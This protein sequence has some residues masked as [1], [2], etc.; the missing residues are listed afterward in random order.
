MVGRIVRQ[1][2]LLVLVIF[3]ATVFAPDAIRAQD[4][5]VF[6]PSPTTAATPTTAAADAAPQFARQPPPSL[7]AT[8]AAVPSVVATAAATTYPGAKYAQCATDTDCVLLDDACKSLTV[9]NQLYIADANAGMAHEAACRPSAAS[10][11][12]IKATCRNGLCGLLPG[13]IP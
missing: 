10:P 7:L 4:V 13:R 1:G 5:I 11:V 6:P 3:A 12:G 9:V 8:T 2:R